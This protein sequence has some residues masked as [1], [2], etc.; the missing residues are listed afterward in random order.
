LLLEL[1]PGRNVE[2]REREE[3]NR[4]A[5]LMASSLR[6]WLTSHYAA[7]GM[8]GTAFARRVSQ[9][10]RSPSL[11]LL[12]DQHRRH[13]RMPFFEEA[14]MLPSEWSAM[15]HALGLFST[16]SAHALAQPPE[17]T[18][19]LVQ[20]AEN[21]ARAAVDSAPPYGEWLGSVLPQPAV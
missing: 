17:R 11:D 7:P 15:L 18:R 2:P 10:T 4:R 6:D 16:P 20:Q 8:H 21:A 14:P 13:R 3:Y 12:I 9:L 1:L 19:A 5:Q